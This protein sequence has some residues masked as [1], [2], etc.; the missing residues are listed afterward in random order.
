MKMGFD[1]QHIFKEQAEL[2]ITPLM[3]LMIILVPILL[4]SI[5]FVQITVLDVNL[6][7]LTGGMS[8]SQKSQSKLEVKIESDGFKVFF[9]EDKLVQEIP[10]MDNADPQSYDYAQ[11]SKV[12]QGV[13]QQLSEKRDVLVLSG[14][15][16]DYQNLVYTMDAVKSFRTVQAL[17]MVEIELFPEI[18]LGDTI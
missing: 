4:I 13:K 18:S 1:F 16:I 12:M 17:N 3:N 11:L 7:E 14:P 8:N 6:P 10:L 2:D 5:N 9:P 15:N